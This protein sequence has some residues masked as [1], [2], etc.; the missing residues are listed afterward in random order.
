MFCEVL[1]PTR[2]PSPSLFVPLSSVVTTTLDTFVCLVRN[3]IVEW[4]KVKKGQ[5]MDGMVEIFGDIHE[6]DLVAKNATDELQPG[7]RVNAS[8]MSTEEGSK[9]A[10]PRPKYQTSSFGS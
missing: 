1:W 10:A 8:L 7:T 2:R 6:G 9:E 5:T 3:N 4:V